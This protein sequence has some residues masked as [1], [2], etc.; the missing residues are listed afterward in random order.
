MKHT[1][2]NCN[3]PLLATDTICWHCG[4]PLT[5]PIRQAISPEPPALDSIE[6]KEPES[7]RASFDSSLVLVYS[8]LVV[9][10]ILGLLVITRSLG[11]SP[12]LALKSDD[13]QIDRVSLTAPDRSFSIEIPAVWEW[14]FQKKGQANSSL[15]EELANESVL[16]LAVQ[17]LGSLVPDLTYLLVAQNDSSLLIVAQSERLNRL[18]PE[19][20][21][22]SLQSEAFD[23]LEVLEVRRVQLEPAAER[24]FITLAHK[25]PPLQC[26]QH[27]VPG[28]TETYLVAACSPKDV[29]DTQRRVM[30][31]ILNSFTLQNR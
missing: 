14:R 31:D 1:C 25:D 15:P 13:A 7:E 24:A 18:S 22:A 17:P 16:G 9:I 28:P 10:I 6:E 3:S 11:Q 26:S 12:I 27:L 21:V 30:L 23:N 29:Y 2:P 5:L 20:A 19:Q 4:Q 8:G